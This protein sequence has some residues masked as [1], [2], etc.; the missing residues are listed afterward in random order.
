MNFIFYVKLK[1]IP[2][3]FIFL[4]LFAWNLETIAEIETRVMAPDFNLKDISS[5]K[6]VTL[7]DVC[8]C[9]LFHSIS[10]THSGRLCSIS[11]HFAS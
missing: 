5:G 11:G 4:M 7:K 6:M 3:L 8:G 2:V 10:T 9:I 1:V